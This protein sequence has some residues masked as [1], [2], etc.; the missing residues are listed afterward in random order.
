MEFAL[1]IPPPEAW[2]PASPMPTEKGPAILVVDDEPALV[3]AILK[4]LLEAGYVAE[5]AVTGRF[6]L[7]RIASRA[8]D[9]MLTD[10]FLPEV[11]GL[12]IIAAVR[13]QQ[14][15]AQIVAISGGAPYMNPMDA[16]RVARRLGACAS[17]EKPFSR[18]DLLVVVRDALAL[19]RG[20]E[21]PTAS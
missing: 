21:S 1:R 19:A 3:S 14:P 7:E 17:L 18:A 8:F 15:K 6:A 11:D 12:E 20:T 4:I 9:V 2:W 5:G 10:I 16:L 13:R